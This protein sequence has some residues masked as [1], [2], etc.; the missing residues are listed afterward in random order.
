MYTKIRISEW[1]EWVSEWWSMS[2]NFKWWQFKIFGRTWRQQSKRK[3]YF[4]PLQKMGSY[5]SCCR[6]KDRPRIYDDVKNDPVVV[7]YTRPFMARYVIKY[8][9]IE[10]LENDIGK[11]CVREVRL[12][13][14]STSLERCY[15]IARDLYRKY[16][17]HE[18]A[19]CY[20]CG[21]PL[22]T[23]FVSNF[24]PESEVEGLCLKCSLQRLNKII[25]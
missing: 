8:T 13:H 5:I 4:L 1:S 23:V 11:L 9:T 6:K 20:R 7:I 2:Q 25:V 21:T 3:R 15:E 16:E 12:F 14:P 17:D 10:K 18:I 22:G 19:C 24:H